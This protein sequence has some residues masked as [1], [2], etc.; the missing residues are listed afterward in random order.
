[1][2]ISTNSV[3]ASVGGTG[4]S[5]IIRVLVPKDVGGGFITLKVRQNFNATQKYRIL[6]AK[7]DKHYNAS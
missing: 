7:I 3:S 4:V 5:A 2:S 6:F 1:M